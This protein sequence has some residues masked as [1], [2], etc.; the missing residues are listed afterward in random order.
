MGMEEFTLFITASRFN[1]SKLLSVL[2]C[3][4]SDIPFSIFNLFLY[5]IC[6]YSSLLQWLCTTSDIFFNLYCFWQPVAMRYRTRESDSCLCSVLPRG[7][8]TDR[9]YLYREWLIEDVSLVV[10]DT[11]C[12]SSWTSNILIMQMIPFNI[13]FCNVQVHIVRGKA[14]LVFV[15]FYQEGYW[16]IGNTCIVNGS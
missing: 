13:I 8:L 9:K 1:K 4:D 5:K 15:L 10:M 3:T 14:T 11:D 6:K 2:R 16:Q 7:I 12:T